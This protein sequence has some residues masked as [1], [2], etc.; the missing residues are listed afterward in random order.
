MLI[1]KVLR[2]GCADHPHR[3]SSTARKSQVQAVFTLPAGAVP[4]FIGALLIVAVLIEPYIIRRK[5]L[6]AHLGAAPRPAATAVADSGGVAIEGAQTKGAMATDR[7]L[8]AR[9]FGKF[10]AR[11]DALAIMLDRRPLVR[12]ACPPAGLLVEPAEHLRAP[13]QLHRS[14]A[15]RGRPHLCDR[16]RRHRPLGRRGAGAGRRQPPPIA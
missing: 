7:A 13:A 12:R 6:A 15:D 1:N 4:A 2:E 16:R 10:L 14:R 3:R 8:T 11:R 5:L 9:G